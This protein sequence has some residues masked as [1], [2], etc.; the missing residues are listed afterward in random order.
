MQGART[1][2]YSYYHQTRH[3]FNCCP[4]IEDSLRQLFREEVMNIH[5][6]ILPTTTIAIP[7]VFVLG[8]QAMNPSIGHIVVF[9]N[10][11]TTWSQ[12]ITPI[13]P[14]KTSMY[15]STYPMWY[16]AIPCFVPLDPSL[17]PTYQIGAKGLD[18]Q[19]FGIYK[20]CT[21]ECVPNN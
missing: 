3:L 14:G 7:N 13:I 5:Q 2:T 6:P 1:M 18:F 19:Y 12:P 9:V 17:Y 16:N 15:T 20:L 21:W 8:T 11:Q 4:F 10:Y